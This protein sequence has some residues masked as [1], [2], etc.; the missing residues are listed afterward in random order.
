MKTELFAEMF[1]KCANSLLEHALLCAFFG[2][3][4]YNLLWVCEPGMADRGPLANPSAV[5]GLL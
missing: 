1:Y 3:R 5:L 4:A 2:V